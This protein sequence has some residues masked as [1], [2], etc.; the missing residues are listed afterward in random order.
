MSQLSSL[1]V[2]CPAASHPVSQSSVRGAK[3]QDPSVQSR[4]LA[5]FTCQ[6]VRGEEE[7]RC[8]SVYSHS[9]CPTQV[10]FR[11]YKSNPLQ[12]I[13]RAKQLCQGESHGGSQ[14]EG[15]H[16]TQA[17]Q[18]RGGVTPAHTPNHAV[19][20]QLCRHDDVA[21][22]HLHLQDHLHGGGASLVGSYH[23]FATLH[24]MSDLTLY[25]S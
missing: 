23:A 1:Q 11:C 18:A 4:N 17:L 24:Y 2:L 16:I 15:C 3:V 20:A 12:F 8:Q 14:A 25:Y 13:G 7:P 10:K 22:Q 5:T 6:S 21:V 19:H 9:R